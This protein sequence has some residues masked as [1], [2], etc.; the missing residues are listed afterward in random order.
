ML[1]TFSKYVAFI[2]YDQSSDPFDMVF[3]LLQNMPSDHIKV[4]KKGLVMFLHDLYVTISAHAI[5]RVC[6]AS[7]DFFI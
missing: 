4:K 2:L 1:N 7:E 6:V 3:Q 5:V